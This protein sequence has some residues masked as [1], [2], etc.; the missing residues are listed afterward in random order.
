MFV[1]P[2]HIFCVSFQLSTQYYHNS[3]SC[4]LS[5]PFS[6]MSCSFAAQC[7]YAHPWRI[8]VTVTL[9]MPSQ[10]YSMKVTLSNLNAL[11]RYASKHQ[12]KYDRRKCSSRRKKVMGGHK[13]KTGYFTLCQEA[14]KAST[15]CPWA[16][17]YIPTIPNWLLCC[18]WS[19]VVFT[20]Q[21]VEWIIQ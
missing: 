5:L 9:P 18:R 10:W 4:M 1:F 13:G 19:I 3:L 14:F 11:K 17:H 21:R 8:T 12:W 7:M 20:L 16:K 15:K 2:I 6:Y